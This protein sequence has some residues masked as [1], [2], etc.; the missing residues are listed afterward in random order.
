MK[1]NLQNVMILGGAGFI[2]SHLAAEFVKRGARVKIIDGLLSRTGANIEN[3]RPIIRDVQFY[4]EKVEDLENLTD[5]M[6]AS[7]LIVDSM[8]LTSHRFGMKHPLL[9]LRLNL[10]SHIYVINA[11]TELPAKKVIY[12]G[13]RA[14]YGKG[15]ESVIDE[16]SPQEP[17]DTQG[18][19]KAAAENLYRIYAKAHGF[20]AIS[21]RVT[22]CFGENQ[23]TEGQDIGL[24]GMFIRDIL[25][26]K[27]VEVFGDSQ[28]E[29]N[30]IYVKDLAKIVAHISE[31]DV[32]T[33][34][35]FNVAG[36]ELSIERLLDSIIGI[37]GKGE[38]KVREFP[39]NIKNIDVGEA[40]Y[41][42]RR[43]KA[44]IGRLDFTNLNVALEKTI[45]YFKD[46]PMGVGSHDI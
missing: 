33:F 43:L 30:I 16:N 41:D 42:D 11:L 12:L 13:S 45:T 38:I 19:F 17:V 3:I 5:L 27:P 14:Q 39:D 25:A 7:D 36:I 20:K 21:L 1:S 32:E 2:G 35:V 6:A 23:K 18:T 15:R 24:V 40:K 28:R 8:G 46:T 26:G 34:E 4:N 31:V 37:V 29:K 22:N 9:D 44:Q 10:I